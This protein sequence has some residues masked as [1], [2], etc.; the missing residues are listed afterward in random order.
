MNLR[1][2]NDAFNAVANMLSITRSG[3]T[4]T[5]VNLGGPVAAS[6]AITPAF[7]N[8]YTCGTPSQRWAAI[9]SATGVIQT[10]DARDKIV[11][12]SLS[13]AAGRMIDAVDPIVFRWRD[14]GAMIDDAPDTPAPPDAVEPDADLHARLKSLP[15]PRDKRVTRVAGKRL[16]AGFKAQ[17]IKAAMTTAGLDFAA[18]GLDDDTK[19]D[20]RQ[21]LRP[22]QLIPVLW[23]ALKETRAE[24]AA[25]RQIRR[26]N[27]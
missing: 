19:P 6:G 5:A 24:V 11:E 3:L 13:D 15:K 22:D 18:W 21:H 8:A 10:S 23:A 4:V 12:A 27:A 26:P 17:D 2:V 14:G 7:D 16:H 20:S 25:L 9:Y 1:G